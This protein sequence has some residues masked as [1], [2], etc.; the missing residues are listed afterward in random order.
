MV[1]IANIQ[2]LYAICHT[3]F[4]P[5]PI[6]LTHSVSFVSVSVVVI[7]LITLREMEARTVRVLNS[8]PCY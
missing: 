7:G 2:P 8:V 1:H 5:V 4:S 6:G 3:H